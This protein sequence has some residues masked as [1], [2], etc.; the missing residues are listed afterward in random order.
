MSRKS[1]GQFSATWFNADEIALCALRALPLRAAVRYRA[2][3]RLSVHSRRSGCVVAS[4]DK[5]PSLKAAYISDLWPGGRCQIDL[6]SFWQVCDAICH[7]NGENCI[8]CLGLRSEV[9][10]WLGPFH[11]QLGQLGAGKQSRQTVCLARCLH[12]HQVAT[13]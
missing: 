10:H 3:D 2:T 12:C 13:N 5:T 9:E 4:F 7:R 8:Y 6:Q 1:G 11:C